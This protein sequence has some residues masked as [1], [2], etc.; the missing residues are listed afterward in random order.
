MIATEKSLEGS[1]STCKYWLSPRTDFGEVE[2]IGRCIVV[3]PFWS[4]T[5]RNDNEQLELKEAYKNKKMFV[6]DAE[7]YCALLYTTADFGCRSWI[8]NP[9]M[10]D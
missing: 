9:N 4:A 5:R 1:C 2:G 8:H 6:Q 10:K 7:D 3:V